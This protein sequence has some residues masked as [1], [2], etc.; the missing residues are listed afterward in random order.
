MLWILLVDLPK[1]ARMS[2]SPSG[3]LAYQHLTADSRR[4]SCP[5]SCLAAAPASLLCTHG[6][7]GLMAPV[8]SL[9][10]QGFK[11]A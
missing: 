5:A 2:S 8:L 4:R 1:A 10:L 3:P 7:I 6:S 9:L 11:V